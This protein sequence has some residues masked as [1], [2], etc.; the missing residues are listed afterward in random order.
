MLHRG[1]GLDSLTTV[2]TG[3]MIGAYYAEHLRRKTG[4]FFGLFCT[5]PLLLHSL[6]A[7]RTGWS[8]VTV[9]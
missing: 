2:R 4:T 7:D 5:S 1:K 3:K 9:G 6:L 8:P